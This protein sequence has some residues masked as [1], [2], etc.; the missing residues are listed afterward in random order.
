MEVQTKVPTPGKQKPL[1]KNAADTGKQ[2][3]QRGVG[4]Q[5]NFITRPPLPGVGHGYKGQQT[6][7]L[8]GH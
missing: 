1:L 5:L 8:T 6:Q 7:E 3:T 2:V 4:K